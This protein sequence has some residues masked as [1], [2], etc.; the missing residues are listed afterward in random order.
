MYIIPKDKLAK[1]SDP[2]H[3]IEAPRKLK[4]LPSL[5]DLKPHPTLDETKN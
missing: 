1:A 4:D 3:G 5:N 2:V